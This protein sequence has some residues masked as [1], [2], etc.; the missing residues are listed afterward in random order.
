MLASLAAAA[1]NKTSVYLVDTGSEEAFTS[2][3]TITKEIN[4]LVGFDMAKV[5][6]WTT[7][8]SR[9]MLPA[10][11]GYKDWG[12]AATDMV[13]NDLV[14]LNSE[15]AA[16]GL[17]IPCKTLYFTNGD[18]LMAKE[19]FVATLDAIAQ[20]HNVVGT[21]F[22]EYKMQKIG[23]QRSNCGGWRTGTN[24]EFSS[25]FR[26]NCIDL[27]AVV[28]SA[29][30]WEQGDRSIRFIANSLRANLTHPKDVRQQEIRIFGADGYTAEAL[31][32]QKDSNPH[33]VNRALVIH[34]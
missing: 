34:Q 20:G 2:L 31:V 6:K 22:I 23:R 16:A 30:L 25:Q 9:P 10:L 11:E 26:L 18:N 7:K 33:I 8:N 5:S 15:A 1:H 21:N 28:S 12:Y 19:F 24:V 29:S 13:I 4:D 14:K 3:L 27:A 32:A 17:P